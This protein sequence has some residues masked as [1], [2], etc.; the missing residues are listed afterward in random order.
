MLGRCLLVLGQ[1]GRIERCGCSGTVQYAGLL[2]IRPH[3]A[4]ECKRVAFL[5]EDLPL[6][7]EAAEKGRIGW[8][9]LCEVTTKATPET[10]ARWLELSE[11]YALSILR[12]LVEATGRGEPPCDPELI[13]SVVPEESW[14]RFRVPTYVASMFQQALR[15]LSLQTGTP[16][17]AAHCQELVFAE[18][19]AGNRVSR[20]RVEKI[21]QEAQ[22]D[23][24]ARRRPVGAAGRQLLLA[25]LSAEPDVLND[26]TVDPHGALECG[27]SAATDPYRRPEDGSSAASC[28]H[29]LLENGPSVVVGLQELLDNEAA[30]P[31]AQPAQAGTRACFD[32]GELVLF[33]PDE[34]AP[35]PPLAALA[36][37][38]AICPSEPRLRLVVPDTDAGWENPRLRFSGEARLA[39][40]A[41]RL[42][43]LRRDGYCC[44]VPGCP[45]KLWLDLHHLV[46]YCQGGVTL[47]SNL[48]VVCTRCHRNLHKG[49]LRVTGTAPDGLRWTTRQGHSLEQPLP[50]MPADDLVDDDELHEADEA[51]FD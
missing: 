13:P 25:E 41:Q 47:P 6:L 46:Y 5:L 34:Q 4:A 38:G 42:E 28:S 48:I 23:V 11:N 19:L 7:R 9:A 37:R 17:S 2:G 18:F 24:A 50:L 16:V 15:Q 1:E 8:G 30:G 10:E 40:P 26:T 20:E 43:M 22:K 36:G 14:L 33:V 45:H 3:E 27:S 35:E 12:R 29:N 32:D 51:G 21:R 44:S 39:T 49:R 31:D